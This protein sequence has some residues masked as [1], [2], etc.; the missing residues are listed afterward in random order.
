MVSI[1]QEKRKVLD[2]HSISYLEIICLRG[3]QLLFS[4]VLFIPFR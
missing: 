1:Y 2:R 4:I 3:A